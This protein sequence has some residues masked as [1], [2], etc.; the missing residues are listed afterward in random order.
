MQ[1]KFNK[2]LFDMDGVLSHLVKDSIKFHGKEDLLP[3]RDVRWHFPLQLGFADTW[4][5]AFWGPLCRKFWGNISP[6]EDGLEL[7]RW[8]E[9]HHGVDRIGILSS[10]TKFDGC[11]DGKQ[12]WVDRFLPQYSKRCFLGSQKEFW[13]DPHVVLVDDHDPNVEKFREKGG[14]AL[15]LPRPWNE[16][17]GETDGNGCFDVP[18]VIEELKELLA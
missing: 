1:T 14:K 5:T 15:L 8:A 4:D 18:R 16:R 11:R 12:D 13:A 17:R 3:I 7:L 2:L 6:H 9:H 10:P